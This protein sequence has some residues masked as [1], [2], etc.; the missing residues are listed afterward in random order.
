MKEKFNVSLLESLEQLST[1]QLD[2][3]LRSELEKK[4]PDEHA[5]RLI[6]KVLR[7]REFNYPVV[8]NKQIDDAWKKYQ[9]NTQP[10]TS[11]FKKILLKA[12]AILVVC[13]MFLFTLPQEAAAVSLFDRIVVWTESIFELFSR[14]DHNNTQKEYIF[15]TEH[16]GLQE[17]YDTVIELGVTK[18]VVPMWLDMEYILID[19][20]VTSTPTTRKLRATFD[21]ENNEVLFEINVYSNSIPKEFQKSEANTTKYER[22]GIVH[23]IFENNGLW[24]IV[25]TR[26]NIECTITI[27]CPE[28]DIRH[29]INSIYT[30]E[31]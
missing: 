24:T 9:K 6:L 16:P 17:L 21:C 1:S 14:S 26:D 25:W 11:N 7:D 31:E 27:D 22:N 2:A 8:S 13:S 18:P 15:Q 4:L 5:V 10:A 28:D 3:M 20:L 19:C 30:M 29:I 12:A 23:Y